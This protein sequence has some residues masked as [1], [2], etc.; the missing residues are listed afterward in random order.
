MRKGFIRE[1]K[2]VAVI[3]FVIGLTVLALIVCVVYYLLVSTQ[4]GADLE[5][6]GQT[7]RPYVVPDPTPTPE[8]TPVPTPAPAEETEMPAWATPTPTPGASAQAGETLDPALPTPVPTNI[9]ESLIAGGQERTA[10]QMPDT[11]ERVRMG[12][13]SCYV[14]APDGY[15]IMEIEGYAYAEHSEYDGANSSSYLIVRSASDGRIMAYLTTPVE[16]VSGIEHQGQGSNLAQSDFRV[17]IDV[18]EYPDGVYTLGTV[19]MFNLSG[20]EVRTSCRLPDTINF[21]VRDGEVI[22]PIRIADATESPSPSPES[23]Q[24]DTAAQQ[25]PAPA[26]DSQ[27]E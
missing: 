7:L 1:G 12:I 17:Y 3:R 11:D 24:G 27:S 22:S 15:R 25:T 16:G 19:L 9:P 10:E 26:T 20:G 14:S 23:A 2:S 21:A 4:Y 8:P 6:P 13:T 18:S 5:R